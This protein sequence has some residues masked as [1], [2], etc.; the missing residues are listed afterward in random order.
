MLIVYLR[1]G[2]EVFT[3]YRSKLLRRR[4]HFLSLSNAR[5]HHVGMRSHMLA[6]E[7]K[8]RL[9]SL[10]GSLDEASLH[11]RRRA[12]R[13]RQLVALPN[14][15]HVLSRLRVRVYDANPGNNAGIRPGELNFMRMGV[16]NR[17]GLRRYSHSL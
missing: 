2:G 8:R 15:N 11:S 5:S 7:Y 9:E 4:I 1:I 3:L 14:L 10:V 12:L 13:R 16:V 6:I 17:T